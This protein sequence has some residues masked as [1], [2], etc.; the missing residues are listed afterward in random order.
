MSFFG[1]YISL[2][3]K[4]VWGSVMFSLA[5]L[6]PLRLTMNMY[7]WLI[8]SWLIYIYEIGT[9]LCFYGWGGRG[10]VFYS[11][12]S[13]LFFVDWFGC[14]LRFCHLEFLREAISDGFMAHSRVFKGGYFLI[15][16]N[17]CKNNMRNWVTIVFFKITLELCHKMNSN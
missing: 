4:F 11:D 13:Q 17:F 14:H 3:K 12:I 7:I 16:I 6:F 2:C 1:I 8:W 10:V 5:K 9:F 15:S